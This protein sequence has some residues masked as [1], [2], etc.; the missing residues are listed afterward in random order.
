MPFNTEDQTQAI[1][2][3][4]L[5]IELTGGERN[6]FTDLMQ[7]CQGDGPDES[8]PNIA[9]VATA[10]IRHLAWMLTVAGGQTIAGALN[11]LQMASLARQV[12]EIGR[13]IDISEGPTS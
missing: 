3:E 11:I 10:T 9:F 5:T 12:D 8:V 7:L 2:T 4:L 1:V 13:D 6:L